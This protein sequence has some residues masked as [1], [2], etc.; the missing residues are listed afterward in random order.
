M[1]CE[2]GCGRE[3]AAGQTKFASA[4]CVLRDAAKDPDFVAVFG[5]EALEATI[6]ALDLEGVQGV[7]RIHGDGVRGNHKGSG[8]GAT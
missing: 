2:C 3:L 8:H 1:K 5:C 4:A 7:Q 6:A